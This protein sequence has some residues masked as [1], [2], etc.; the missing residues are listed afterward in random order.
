[1]DVVTSGVAKARKGDPLTLEEYI[2]SHLGFLPGER[3]ALEQGAPGNTPQRELKAGS[4]ETR[5]C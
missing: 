1:M 5:R 4:H 3:E 2:A